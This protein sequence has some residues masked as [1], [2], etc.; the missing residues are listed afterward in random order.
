MTNQKNSAHISRIFLAS[1]Y[2]WSGLKFAWQ[3]GAFR[4]ECYIACICITFGIAINLSIL[5]HLGILC[6]WLFV[7]IIE[8]LNSAI[9]ACI[10][11][12]SHEKHQLSKIAKDLGS[13]AV[14]LSMIICII[15]NLSIFI[16]HI[17]SF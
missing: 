11:R 1:K 13:A 15:I 3:E 5:Q 12:I 8:I 10:D 4:L 17:T 16:S 14:F 6:S 9:E 7:L 2:S